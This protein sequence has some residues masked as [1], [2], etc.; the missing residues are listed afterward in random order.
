MTQAN[1]G[2]CTARRNTKKNSQLRLAAYGRMQAS[3]RRISPRSSGRMISSPS[4]S[5]RQCVRVSL[6]KGKTFLFALAASVATR[7]DVANYA[8]SCS[9]AA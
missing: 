8:T 1:S 2:N 6:F 9:L 7:F 3:T 5:R 4:G